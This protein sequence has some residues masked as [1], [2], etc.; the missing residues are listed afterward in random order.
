[1][2]GWPTTAFLTPSG[3]IITGRT[4]IPPQQMKTLLAQVSDY[5]KRNKEKIETEIKGLEK[6]ETQKIRPVQPVQADFQSVIDNVVLM[7]L[8]NFDQTY[9]GF[10]SAPKFPNSDAVSFALLE[11]RLQNQ[12]VLLDIVIKTLTK[13]QEG[14]IYDKV[15]GG[16]FRYSTTRDW[17]VPHYEKMCED[18]AQL[19]VNYLQAFQVTRND[20]FKTTAQQVL[21]YVDN[22][23]G[24]R[25]NGG[26]YG[27]Q[28]ADEEYY[29]L[30]LPER[31]KRAKP[32]MDKTLYTNYN[33][34]MISTY[35][36][37][38]VVLEERRYG[39]FAIKTV[40][41]LLEKCFD[42]KEGMCHFIP[43]ND[44]PTLL[45]DQAHMIR[46]LIDT[47]HWTADK[48]FLGYAESIATSM[49]QNLWNDKYSFV[50]RSFNRSEL[51]MLRTSHSPFD[52]N[53]RAANDFL[54]L[55]YLTG[56][57]TYREKALTILKRFFPIYENFE[58]IASSYAI[59]VETYLHAVQVHIVGS[60]E[61]ALTQEYLHE[62]IKAYNPL[63]TI[64]VVN[65]ETDIERLKTLKYPLSEEVR[66]Y[67][68]A[69]GKCNLA[70]TPED[71]SKLLSK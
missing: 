4:Y 60:R 20:A 1:M 58:V 41:L 59:A 3:K 12:K 62:A 49:L 19:L 22:N 2:G 43:N 69:E 52:E 8:E 35:L 67:V 15:E 56:N 65:P 32:K 29:K 31:E 66:A 23:L 38:S 28:D 57:E 55:S 5:Y 61:K 40:N 45:A 27:S 47:Y 7:I 53:A 34:M 16:F 70:K 37:A 54:R 33:A 14:E 39:N 36:L 24:D 25:D 44:A 11:S 9:G 18:N 17:S 42:N 48:R 64:E 51:G 26:F 46:A 68:C 13:M 71:I 21:N 50:D 6:K 10:G 63:K 30:S